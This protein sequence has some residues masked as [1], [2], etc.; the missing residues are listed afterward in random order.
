MR[1][2]IRR[3]L[4][5]WTGRPGISLF[6]DRWYWGFGASFVIDWADHWHFDGLYLFLDF[7]PWALTFSY[8]DR[9]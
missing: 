8:K 7:G 4:A 2:V 5:F 3:F 1:S 6:Y 9:D